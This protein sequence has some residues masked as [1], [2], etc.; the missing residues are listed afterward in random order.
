MIILID[1]I[2]ADTTV[3]DEM[4]PDAQTIE[5]YKDAVRL[6]RGTTFH[7]V[8]PQYLSLEERQRKALSPDSP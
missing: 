7:D 5:D 3:L 1:G 8:P 2:P 6:E 4:Y